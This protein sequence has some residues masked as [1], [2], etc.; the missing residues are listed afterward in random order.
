[1]CVYQSF[2]GFAIVYLSMDV[3]QILNFLFFSKSPLP[4]QATHLA[5]T[6]RELLNIKI[7]FQTTLVPSMVFKASICFYF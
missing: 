5:L 7:S 4:L 1:M 6:L 3:H 2:A